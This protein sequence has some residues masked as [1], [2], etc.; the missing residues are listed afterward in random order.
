MS[1]RSRRQKKT[2][3]R[4]RKS[5]EMRCRIQDRT[6]STQVPLT[7]ARGRSG[8]GHEP[9]MVCWISFYSF[10]SFELP[11]GSSPTAY[12]SRPSLK[13]FIF[14]P[15]HTPTTLSQQHALFLF[16]RLLFFYPVY[17]PPRI[18]TTPTTSPHHLVLI[19]STPLRCKSSSQI[20]EISET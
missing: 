1:V 15:S 17:L 14:S 7:E 19:A 5:A 6:R 12:I 3:N 10:P 16:S 18:S 9:R 8:T 20:Q 11:R 13:P 4:D 2:E